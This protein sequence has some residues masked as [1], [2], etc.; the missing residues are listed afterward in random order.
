MVLPALAG[1]LMESFQG[2]ATKANELQGALTALPNAIMGFVQAFSPATVQAFNLALG[3]FMATLGVAL[4]PVLSAFTELTR[5][6]ADYL[7]PVMQEL[8]P[9]VQQLAQEFLARL[10]P[11]VQMVAGIL[12]DMM[13][14]F[15]IFA[16]IMK[17]TT[18][19]LN[20]LTVIFGAL[21]RSVVQFI[22]S[23][24]GENYQDAMQGFQ[25]AL[26][27][28]ANQLL[29]LVGQI[30]TIFGATGFLNNLI[31]GLE[32]G[33]KGSSAGMKAATNP[34]F[35]SFV[36]YGRDVALAASVAGGQ[37]STFTQE[38]FFTEA[39]A[40]LRELAANPTKFREEILNAIK[41]LPGLIAKALRGGVHSAAAQA[42]ENNPKTGGT[43][44]GILGSVSPNLAVAYKNLIFGARGG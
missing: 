29:V 30:A 22:A 2:L 38:E 12:R 16:D 34:A 28:L 11:V 9:I 19:V 31:S 18:P 32:G 15:Q 42:V 40:K 21:I 27:R 37:K 33:K 20:A 17:A 43:I 23:L 8:R 26:K 25:D 5:A 3:D 6:V 7:L 44:A 35:K 36:D 41:A 10:I 4:E 14:L 39:I 1:A 13:P 24:F